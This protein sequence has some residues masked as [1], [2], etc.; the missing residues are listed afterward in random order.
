MLILIEPLVERRRQRE[1]RK[2][3]KKSARTLVGGLDFQRLP[4]GKNG[5]IKAPLDETANIGLKT[6]VVIFN[7]NKYTVYQE[8]EDLPSANEEK[9]ELQ[10]SL[11]N[12]DSDEEE[13]L[14]E[15]DENA[16]VKTTQR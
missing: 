1:W 4:K 2:R 6:A 14:K 12:S 5:V 13:E 11:N 9:A 3:G 15:D 10:S 7:P 8:E 16:K